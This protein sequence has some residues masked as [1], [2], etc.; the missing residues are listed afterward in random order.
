MT[1]RPATEATTHLNC[2][3][4]EKGRTPP[5]LLVSDRRPSLGN[6]SNQPR[7]SVTG[8]SLPVALPAYGGRVIRFVFITQHACTV[9]SPADGPTGYQT[10]IVDPTSTREVSAKRIEVGGNPPYKKNRYRATSVFVG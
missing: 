8:K 7:S 1:V 6:T 3:R 2:L 10:S 9:V 4:W 5:V